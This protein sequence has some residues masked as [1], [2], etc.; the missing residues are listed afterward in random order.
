MALSDKELLK[1][2]TIG[3]NHCGDNIDISSTFAIPIIKKAY[4]LGQIHYVVGD[5]MRSVDYL[6]NEEILKLIKN[7]SSNGYT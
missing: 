5:D 1:Y 2:Y 4:N 7:K 3:W 6:S